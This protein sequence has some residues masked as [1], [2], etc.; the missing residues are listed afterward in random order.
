MPNPIES[1]TY[2][3]PKKVN[4]T[5]ELLKS[6][7]GWVI[8]LIPYVYTHLFLPG[9]GGFWWKKFSNKPIYRLVIYVITKF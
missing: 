2:S 7:A 1:P 3:F 6:I 9:K 8:Y 5:I 4:S